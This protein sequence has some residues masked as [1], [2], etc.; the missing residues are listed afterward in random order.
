MSATFKKIIPLFNRIV[1]RKVVP[2]S[3]TK[4]GI[5][6]QKADGIN[7][8]VVLEVGPG[9][10]DSNGKLVPMSLKVGDTV[11]LPEFGGTTVKLG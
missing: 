9:S 2:E 5:I 10:H 7:H 6:L 3:K 4:S 11:L 8:G 1:V